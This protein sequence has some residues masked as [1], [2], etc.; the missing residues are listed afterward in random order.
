MSKEEIYEFLEKLKIDKH[1][2][3]IGS[4][5]DIPMVY[6]LVP[7]TRKATIKKLEKIGFKFRVRSFETSLGEK[8]YKEY[9]IKIHN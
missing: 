1:L 9:G 4:E 8:W 3:N 2:Y 6:V 7:E 5:N